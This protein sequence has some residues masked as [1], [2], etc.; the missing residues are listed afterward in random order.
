MVVIEEVQDEELQQQQ[1]QQQQQR[2]RASASGPR[3]TAAGGAA[4]GAAAGFAQEGDWK[5]DDG[6]TD[7][8]L[9]DDDEDDDEDEDEDDDFDDDLSKETLFDRIAA[10]KDIIPPQ[11]RRSI[12]NTVSTVSDVAWFGGRIIGVLGWV[13]TT[14][15]LVVALPLMLAVED[16]SRIM[17]QEREMPPQGM[18]GAPALGQPQPG[19][20]PGQP[21][22][23]TP[24]TTT[25]SGIRAPG[26]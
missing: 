8:G 9:L 5:T 1:Q 23:Q 7:D 3:R 17:Q 2:S 14:S 16:E 25:P 10:L 24:G 4:G 18:M 20:L 19:Q 26:F 15:A 22:Q 13:V 21:D 12:A 6:M 11:T